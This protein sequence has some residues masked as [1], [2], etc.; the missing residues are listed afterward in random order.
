MAS[1]SIGARGSKQ[2]DFRTEPVISSHFRSLILSLLLS[3][4]LLCSTES[5]ES[6]PNILTMTSG[7]FSAL[8]ESMSISLR[9][10]S[11]RPLNSGGKTSSSKLNVERARVTASENVTVDRIT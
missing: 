4:T 11:R 2:K 1:V 6:S 7:T 5:P 9:F 10:F 8:G 3:Y